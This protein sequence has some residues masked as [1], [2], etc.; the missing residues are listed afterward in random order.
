MNR[1]NRED[2]VRELA[3][4]AKAFLAVLVTWMIVVGIGT[5]AAWLLD[6]MTK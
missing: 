1:L 5:A 4:A 2:T 6:H 3:K